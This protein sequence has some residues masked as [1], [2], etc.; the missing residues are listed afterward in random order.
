MADYQL[1]AELLEALKNKFPGMEVNEKQ[2]VAIPAEDLLPLITELK[3]NPD[4]AM[5]YLTNLTAVEYKDRFEMVYNLV[6]LSHGHTLTVK[7]KIADKENPE[8][9]SLSPVFRGANWQEREAYDLMGILFTGYPDHPT[10]I[11]LEEN[12]KGYPLRKDFRWE[13]GREA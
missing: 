10:R 1:P 6:S 3:E 12:F 2:D 7:V 4:Y 11:F 9:P 5:D 13:G 8:V